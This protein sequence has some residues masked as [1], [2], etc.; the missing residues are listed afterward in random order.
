MSDIDPKNVPLYARGANWEDTP[1]GTTFRTAARTITEP[2]LMS[3]VSV[4][5]LTEPLFLDARHA[6]GDGYTG[7]LVPGSMTFC[8]AEGLVMQ[9]NVIHGTGMAFMHTD[10][11][12]RK[13]V[14]VG[15][16]IE[17]VVEITESRASSRAGAGVVTARNTV[18][19]QGGEV[20]MEY[21]PVRLIRGRDGQAHA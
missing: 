18:F 11:D 19:N 16:T 5:G 9:T 14:Y 10:L 12:V 13:P 1:T 4:C 8:I 2:D 15:D 17:V 20:V 3:F 7:R 6:G 21:T